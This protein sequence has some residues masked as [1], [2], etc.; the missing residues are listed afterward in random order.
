MAL[1]HMT[2]KGVT[3]IVGKGCDAALPGE[4]VSYYCYFFQFPSGTLLVRLFSILDS[5]SL[6]GTTAIP[7]EVSDME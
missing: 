5:K 6:T 2:C 4:V 3:Q 7:D 1:F